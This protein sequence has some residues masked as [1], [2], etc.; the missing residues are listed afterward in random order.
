M[1][2]LWAVLELESANN[3]WKR[4]V[5]P[6]CKQCANFARISTTF[7]FWQNR[8]FPRIVGRFQFQN[9]PQNWHVGNRSAQGLLISS[10]VSY[11]LDF[12]I[13]LHSLG[14]GPGTSLKHDKT[15]RATGRSRQSF[16]RQTKSTTPRVTPT[17]TRV[18]VSGSCTCSQV[19]HNGT[20]FVSSLFST[21][22][23][24]TKKRLL[25]PAPTDSCPH[26]QH[27]ALATSPSRVRAQG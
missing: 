17:I 6:K 13:K 23:C 22:T 18:P 15:N 2:V 14:P 1:P 5:L 3:S 26:A 7:A 12:F 24:N 20:S 25:N 8:S 27:V 16:A 10:R 11:N 9:C 21:K 4:A 19:S